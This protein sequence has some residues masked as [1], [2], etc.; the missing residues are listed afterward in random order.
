[1]ASVSRGHSAFAMFLAVVL[2]MA[3]VCRAQ[4]P[5]GFSKKMIIGNLYNPIDIEF[6]PSGAML[7][8]LR[9]GVILQIVNGATVP[10]L[11]ISQNV[12]SNGE[13]GELASSKWKLRCRVDGYGA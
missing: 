8:V 3:L 1:M 7:A 13:K 5:T 2:G 11:D 12:D 4:L 9:H 6:L 10:Y